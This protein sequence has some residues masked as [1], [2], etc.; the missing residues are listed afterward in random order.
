[1]RLRDIIAV[2]LIVFVAVG[3]KY[4]RMGQD[5]PPP[6]RRPDP[7]Q[8]EPAPPTFPE[9][10]PNAGRA[11]AP[12]KNSDPSVLV[13]V[14]TKQQNAVGTAFSLNRSGVWITAH[15]VTEG[16]DLVVLQR[17]DGKSVVVRRIAEQRHAD[18]SIMWTK[19][20]TPALP[21]SNPPL[22]VGEDGYS[23]GFPHGR[24]GDVHGRIIGNARLIASGRYRT[25]E[26]VIAW[27]QVRRIPD[28]G[29][30]LGGISGGPWLNQAGDVIGVHVAGSPRRGRSYSTTPQ[31][32][33]TALSLNHVVPVPD[34]AAL[35]GNGDLMPGGFGQYGDELRRRQ[36]VAK[37]ICLVGEKWRHRAAS[38]S[39]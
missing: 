9:V 39:G 38:P 35:P 3:G 14:E 27:T 12:P 36:T 34:R 18:I 15:H 17:N 4:Y 29:T 5:H 32:L 1:M 25:T 7:R 37:V 21:V 20:G 8:F 28:E 33:L 16:C 19:G 31:A 13:E 10:P 23:F 24:P 6:E 26:P 30:N 22:T 2:L 11:L